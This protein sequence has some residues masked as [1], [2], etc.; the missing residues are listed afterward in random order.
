MRDGENTR[1][2]VGEGSDEDVEEAIGQGGFI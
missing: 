2:D 1:G